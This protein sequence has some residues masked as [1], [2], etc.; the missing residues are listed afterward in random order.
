MLQVDAI[1]NAKLKEGCRFPIRY[2]I[3]TAA[4]IWHGGKSSEAYP[5]ESYNH[6]SLPFPSISTRVYGY[7]VGQTAKIVVATVCET[8]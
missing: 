5:L 4:P 6:Y 7:P 3:H 1:D 8:L 2:V